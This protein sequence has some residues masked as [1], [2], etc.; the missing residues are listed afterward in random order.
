[1]K[2]RYEI[3]ALFEGKEFSIIWRE[4]NPFVMLY[5]QKTAEQ[6]ILPNITNTNELKRKIREQKIIPLAPLPKALSPRVFLWKIGEFL[7][8]KLSTILFTA[9]GKI[10]RKR[11]LH[12]AAPVVFSIGDIF[13]TTGYKLTQKVLSKTKRKCRA[14][15]FSGGHRLLIDILPSLKERDS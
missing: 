8:S 13:F 1:M 5:S 9:A 14:P 15:L 11:T 3:P 7:Y 2:R 4:G 10:E 6:S 12:S